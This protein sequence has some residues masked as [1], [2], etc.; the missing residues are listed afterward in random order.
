[1]SRH[2]SLAFWLVIVLAGAVAGTVAAA[3]SERAVT[4]TVFGETGYDWS[5]LYV[6]PDGESFEELP[7][8]RYTRSAPL[9]LTVPGDRIRVYR[10]DLAD[11]GTLVYPVAG[12]AALGDGVDEVLLFFFAERGRT[13]RE[14]RGR[15]RVVAMDDSSVALP[16]DHLVFFNATGVQL[17]GALDTREL[18]LN[19]GQS[20]AFDLRGLFG[21]E[22]P[23]GF[24]VRSGETFERVLVN[25][26]RFSP[27]R[28]TVILLLPPRRE[29]SYRIQAVRLSEA[30]D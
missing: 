30:A 22:V 24:V 25:R 11:D 18:T 9:R 26:M 29:E 23:V 1:M 27:D 28:R 6:S 21:R 12:E 4:F 20:R 14:G 19:P 7:F 16:R 2:R 8:V 3:E 5:G 13:P 10:R 17:F 15:F